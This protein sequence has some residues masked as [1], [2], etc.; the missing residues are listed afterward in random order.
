MSRIVQV[1]GNGVDAYVTFHPKVVK[2]YD[3]AHLVADS[4]VALLAYYFGNDFPWLLTN[5]LLFI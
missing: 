5:T 2:L 3:I 4:T 1:S